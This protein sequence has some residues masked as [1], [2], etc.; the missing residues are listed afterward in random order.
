MRIDH[1]PRKRW[2]VGKRRR[3]LPSLLNAVEQKQEAEERSL[4][5]TFGFIKN[6]NSTDSK[7]RPF[8]FFFFPGALSFLSCSLLPWLRRGTVQEGQPQLAVLSKAQQEAPSQG[9]ARQ[10]HSAPFRANH[11]HPGHLRVN[12]MSH[13]CPSPKG[14]GKALFLP[15]CEHGR[16]RCGVAGIHGDEGTRP[17]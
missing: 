11:G 17:G 9:E 4:T 15:F 3:R 2:K 10:E 16:W 7:I 5:H 14:K 12:L 6:R 13:T 1:T 8:F